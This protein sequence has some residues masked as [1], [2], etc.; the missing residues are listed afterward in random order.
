MYLGALCLA[1]QGTLFAVKSCGDTQT[2]Q[3]QTG[4][5]CVAVLGVLRSGFRTEVNDAR[6]CEIPFFSWFCAKCPKNFKNSDKIAG[7]AGE[8]VLK[9]AN[10]VSGSV[11]LLN[12]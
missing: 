9:T 11:G 12:R 1:V 10:A 5:C 2:L 3:R 8:M 4:G 6:P 7:L